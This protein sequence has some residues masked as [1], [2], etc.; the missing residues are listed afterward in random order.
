[1]GKDSYNIEP[2]HINVSTPQE[3]GKQ[4]SYPIK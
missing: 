4:K 1:M 3:R 2:N